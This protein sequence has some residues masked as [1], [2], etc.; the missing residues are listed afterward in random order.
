M[1]T[2]HLPN[3]TLI[4]YAQGGWQTSI[5]IP[6][7]QSV[8]DVG[9]LLPVRANH[10]FIT[11]GHPDHMDAL[12][13][14]IA[15]QTIEEK[16]KYINLYY[17]SEIDEHLKIGLTALAKIQ[18]DRGDLP[19]HFHPA[20][21]GDVFQIKSGVA[22]KTLKTYHRIPSCGWAVE[23]STKKLLPEYSTLSTN[24][25]IKLKKSGKTITFDNSFISI[26]IPGDTTIDFL[27]LQEQA[28]NT[29]ILTHEVTSWGIHSRESCTR[30]GHTHVD[31]ILEFG[32]LFNGD[33]LVLVHR[34]MKHTRT[35]I[36]GIIQ[37]KF[38][39]ELMH[40]IRLFDGG[41]FI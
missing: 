13:Y 3:V 15:R 24:D 9:V 30:Y 36:E 1:E 8:F 22:V 2:L 35:E 16:D 34:S 26:V 23:Q 19:V 28:Q 33:I 41:D 39:T 29:K 38:P 5:H 25:I 27:R 17:P 31:D 20:S 40:K 21:P 10:Y 14:L 18:G 37:N 6:E 32:H 4:G 7:I 12:S 11:H